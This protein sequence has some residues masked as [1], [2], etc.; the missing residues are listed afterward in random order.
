[1]CSDG[2]V[3]GATVAGQCAALV[4]EVKCLVHSRA[5]AISCADV[6][7]AAAVSVA[8]SMPYACKVKPMLAGERNV[9][10]FALGREEVAGSP[11][12]ACRRFPCGV[13]LRGRASCASWMPA[14]ERVLRRKH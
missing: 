4:E 8:S 6:P 9:R 11:R 1:V 7:S 5:A 14:A 2:R 3:N 13:E 10:A 12:P